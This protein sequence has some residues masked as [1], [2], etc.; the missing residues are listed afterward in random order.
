MFLM[1]G[2]KMSTRAGKTVELDKVLVEAVERAKKLGNES[3][4]N[5]KAVGIGAIK[6]F[7]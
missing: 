2:K 3:T 5:A 6:Y 7:D 1:D 4:I